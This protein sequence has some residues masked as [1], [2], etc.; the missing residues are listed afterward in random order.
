VPDF[1]GDTTFLGDTL[2]GGG[3]T[4]DLPIDWS[5]LFGGLPSYMSDPGLGGLTGGQQLYFDN[6]TGQLV[7]LAQAQAIDPTFQPSNQVGPTSTADVLRSGG[8]QSTGSFGYGG[9]SNTSESIQPAQ[10]NGLAQALGIAP[11][12]LTALAGLGMLGGATAAAFGGGNRPG[13]STQ[14]QTTTPS[15]LNSP[16]VQGLLGTPGAPGSAGGAYTG[17]TGLQGAAGQ[18]TANLQGPQGLLQR[19]I[20]AIPQLNPQIQAAI[21]QNALGF[22][23]GNVPTL[24][25]PQAQQY[26]QNVLGGQNAAVDYNTANSLTDAI[27]NLRARGFAGGSEIFREGAPAAAMGPVLAQ[28][29]AQKAMN[30]GNINAQQLQYATQL[31]LLGSQLNTQQL[32]QQAVPFGAYTTAAQT[33]SQI[34]Q[35]LLQALMAQ[36]GSTTTGTST[37]P[38]PNLLQTLGGIVPLLGAAGGAFSSPA[39][40]GSQGIPAL[41]I[42]PTP[43]LFDRLGGLFG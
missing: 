37:G 2:F 20:G 19:Q 11:A 31:P 39:V 7:T 14:T 3:Q 5:G 29:N 22:S 16:A 25:N 6:Q 41:G 26:F 33:Q 30:L 27:Q 21:G 12:A 9:T 38:Q 34:P 4:Y 10:L 17:G 13:T 28:A 36:G 23:Q 8:S 32:G 1:S 42:Q 40:A 43:G 15:A 18:A 35:A 24:N